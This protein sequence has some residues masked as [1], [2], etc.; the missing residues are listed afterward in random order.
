MALF[1]CK[2]FQYATSYPQSGSRIQLG[3]SYQYDVPSTAPDQRTIT[4]TFSGMH[5]GAAKADLDMTV[6]ETFYRQHRLDRE[7]EFVHP[8]YGTLACKFLEPL[9][10]PKVKPGGYGILEDFEVKLIEIP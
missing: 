8:N 4:L 6:L 1:P 10:I 9:N 2:I 5:Y 3:N 7:F